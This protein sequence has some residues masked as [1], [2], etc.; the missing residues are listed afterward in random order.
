M[1]SD[2]VKARSSSGRCRLIAACLPVLG[3]SGRPG[4]E[5]RRPRRWTAEKARAW[6]GGPAVDARLQLHP[7][8]GRQHP[9]DVA[10]GDLRPGRHR[11]GARLGRGPRLQRGPG[12]PP[13]SPVAAGPGRLPAAP[14]A[15]PGDRRQ[16]PYRD[17]VRPLRR[18]LESQVRASGRSRRRGRA[19]TTRAGSSAPGPDLLEDPGALGRPRGLY[20]RCH[21]LLPRRPPRPGLGPLQRAGEFGL[22]IEVAAPPQE[23]SSPGPGRPRRPSR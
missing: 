7:P 18:L 17:D 2:E 3:G 4:R 23:R 22:R 19:S 10:G 6:A 8:D 11:P 14:R 1:E 12:L 16:A 9:G 21:R 20:A 13:L 15:V 5:D